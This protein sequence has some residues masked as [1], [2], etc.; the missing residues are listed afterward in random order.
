MNM[1]A[2]LDDRFNALMIV[3]ALGC[4]LAL[5]C[6]SVQGNRLGRDPSLQTRAVAAVPTLAAP[7]QVATVR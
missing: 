1:N 2:R 6:A 7:I 3:A 5:V 4:A